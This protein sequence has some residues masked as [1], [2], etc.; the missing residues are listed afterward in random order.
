MAIQV[1]VHTANTILILH[2]LTGGY[3]TQYSYTAQRVSVIVAVT[4]AVIVAVQVHKH[5]L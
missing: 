4:V 2:S 1:R 5:Q 3:T